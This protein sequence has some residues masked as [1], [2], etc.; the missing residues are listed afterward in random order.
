MDAYYS[1]QIQLP[2][3]SGAARQRRS[4][5]GAL[6]AT[7][8][9][10]ALP[11]FRNVLFPAA[12]KFTQNVVAEAAPE[13]INLI[14]GKT[15]IKRATKRTFAQASKKTLQRGSG[16]SSSKSAKKQR[17]LE[18]LEARQPLLPSSPPSSSRKFTS[19]KPRVKRSRYDILGNLKQ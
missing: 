6:A 1:K 18:N 2:Y 17:K 7:I 16:G 8:G 13:M 12:K 11:I 14:D 5:L 4:G 15:S 10:F 9:R 19:K 3:Y